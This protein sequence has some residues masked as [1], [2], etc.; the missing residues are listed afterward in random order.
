MM[1]SLSQ[2][3]HNCKRTRLKIIRTCALCD[4]QKLLSLRTFFRKNFCRRSRSVCVESRTAPLKWKR[5]RSILGMEASTFATISQRCQNE[6]TLNLRSR[7]TLFYFCFEILSSLNLD[8]DLDQSWSRIKTFFYID[9]SLEINCSSFAGLPQTCKNLSS[10]QESRSRRQGEQHKFLHL[11][12]VRW[13]FLVV[14]YI[15]CVQ[16]FRVVSLF[17]FKEISFAYEVLSNPEKRETYYRPGLEGLKE[18]AGGGGEWLA[19]FC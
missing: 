8:L 2:V 5:N 16:R 14:C 10:R 3:P 12:S 1:L 7:S 9:L 17:Q 19:F 6:W 15:L 11:T 4:P 18:G 13:L